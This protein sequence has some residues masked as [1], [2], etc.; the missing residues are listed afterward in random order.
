MVASCLTRSPLAWGSGRSPAGD[1]GILQEGVGVAYVVCLD[2][3]RELPYDWEEMR[4]ITTRAEADLRVH[5]LATKRAA[6]TSRLR[7]IVSHPFIIQ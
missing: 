5:A 2:C 4:V 1:R 3:G 6:R 7:G